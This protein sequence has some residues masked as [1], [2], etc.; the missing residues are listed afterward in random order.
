MNFLKPLNRFFI[1][2]F[3]GLF[4]IVLSL[5]SFANEPKKVLVVDPYSNDREDR[6]V[7]QIEALNYQVAYTDLKDAVLKWIEFQP[8]LI[9]FKA[10]Y[11]SDA[12]LISQI[13][14][15]ITQIDPSDR[16][17]I[18]I[19][20]PNFPDYFRYHLA[21]NSFLSQPQGEEYLSRPSI[22]LIDGAIVAN[23]DATERNKIGVKQLF[24]EKVITGAQVIKSRMV[25]FSRKV[26]HAELLESLTRDQYHPHRMVYLSEL[27]K[28][29]SRI[30]LDVLKNKELNDRI[31]PVKELNELRESIQAL[32]SLKQKSN[33]ESDRKQVIESISQ[34]LESFRTVDAVAQEI[35]GEALERLLIQTRY[36]M[37]TESSKNKEAKLSNSI[38]QCMN[39]FRSN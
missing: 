22:N 11:G 38:S 25:D 14:L 16:A 39:F 10:I 21:G 13:I 26:T 5:V 28:D 34:Q 24:L 33:L 7:E 31:Y 6:I 1:P 20:L 32:R 18:I 9:L 4:F 36:A 29:P 37:Q 2:Q 8:N 15:E 17:K 12:D 35:K 30:R 27:H 3:I 19:T 23:F